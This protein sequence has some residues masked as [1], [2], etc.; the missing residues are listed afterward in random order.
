MSSFETLA[1]AK[2]KL[3]KKIMQKCGYKWSVVYEFEVTIIFPHHCHFICDPLQVP[4][5]FRLLI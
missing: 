1:G 4:V 5:W 3:K 2:K